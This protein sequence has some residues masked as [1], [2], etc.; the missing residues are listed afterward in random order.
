LKRQNPY[1]N[2]RPHLS[3]VFAKTVERSAAIGCE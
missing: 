3:T 2:A 1:L